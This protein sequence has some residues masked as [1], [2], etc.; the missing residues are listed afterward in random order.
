MNAEALEALYVVLFWIFIL[1]GVPGFG[2]LLSK[3]LEESA[4]ERRLREQREAVDRMME[5]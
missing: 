3:R 5:T 2:Y 4:G 1:F